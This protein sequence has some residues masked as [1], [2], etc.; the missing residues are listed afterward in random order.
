MWDPYSSLVTE[1]ALSTGRGLQVCFQVCV[2]PEQ[3]I[4]L[5]ANTRGVSI[6]WDM[7]LICMMAQTG[8][9][10]FMADGTTALWYWF[11]ALDGYH[12][13]A[14]ECQFLPDEV[15]WVLGVPWG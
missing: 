5:P 7:S 1:M 15:G 14:S 2:L 4:T 13:V 11:Q 8:I 10:I 12:E 9:Y 6:P 3:L